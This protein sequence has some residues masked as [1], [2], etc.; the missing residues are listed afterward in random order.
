MSIIEDVKGLNTNSVVILAIFFVSFIA[1]AFLLIYRLNPELFLAID[2]T[3]LII[4]SISVTSPSFLALF[5]VTWVGDTV[6]THMGYHEKGHLGTYLD[7][8][9]THG[10]S[11]TT[12]MYTVCFI[13]YAFGIS[14]ATAVWWIIGLVVFY[15]VFEFWRILIV[16]K[17]PH[18][19]KSAINRE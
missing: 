13:V 5:I 10:I 17:S 6:L 15:I 9:V 8:F 3:K 19:K 18:F 7:W 14:S 16:A 2:A 12:I 1:P 11:N 4:L